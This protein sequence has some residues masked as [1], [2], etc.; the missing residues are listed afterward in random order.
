MFCFCHVLTVLNTHTGSNLYSFAVLLCVFY[1]EICVFEG[2]R[3]LE[4]V[5]LL[6]ASRGCA[7]LTSSPF[8]IIVHRHT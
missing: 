7:D 1:F 8:T 4:A 6:H 5:Q 3:L 2:Q